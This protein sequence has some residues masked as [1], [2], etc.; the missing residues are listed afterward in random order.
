VEVPAPM[1]VKMYNKYMG[2]VDRHDQLRTLFA[3]GK[4]LKF[5]KYYVKLFFLLF[6]VGM[7]NAWI[8]YR[9]VIQELK[10]CMAPGQ[11]SFNLLLRQW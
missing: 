7:P 9:N 11:T 6:D 1:A 8:H 3:L 4:K 2:G 5:R 10:I